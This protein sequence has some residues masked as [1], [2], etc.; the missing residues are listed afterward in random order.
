MGGDPAVVAPGDVG[1]S[2][3]GS[4]RSQA[5]AALEALGFKG[6]EA[7]RM[8]KKSNGGSVEEIVR[9]ALKMVSP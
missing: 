1:S 5:I 8:V 6:A 7:Q 3:A 2:N 9:D 4:D